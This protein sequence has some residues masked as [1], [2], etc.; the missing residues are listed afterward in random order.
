MK[1]LTRRDMLRFGAAAAA[2]ALALPKTSFAGQAKKVGI[3]VQLYS[4]RDFCGKDFDAA[5]KQVA[6]MGFEGVEFAGYHKYASDAAGLRKKLDDLGLKA[7]G[8]HIGA[9]SFV[10]DD[11]KK[12]IEF[13]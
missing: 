13:H 12:T 5:L 6:G 9:G 3:A 4:V 8:T 2:A 7:A 1:T 11:L 10:G